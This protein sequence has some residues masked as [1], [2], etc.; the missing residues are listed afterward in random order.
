MFVHI[1][2]FLEGTNLLAGRTPTS[3]LEKGGH[4]RPPISGADPFPLEKGPG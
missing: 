4:L 1:K 2:I 3:R